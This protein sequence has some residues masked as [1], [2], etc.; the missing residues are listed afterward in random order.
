MFCYNWLV[1]PRS[2]WLHS[3]YEHVSLGMKY[4]LYDFVVLI[5]LIPLSSGIFFHITEGG[6][7]C[8]LEEVPED[9]LIAGETI[10]LN[11]T[12]KGTYKV[13]VLQGKEFL[14]SPDYGVHVEVY[15]PDMK[16]ILSRVSILLLHLI[17]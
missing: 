8:F 11:N 10:V 1:S 6:V 4:L 12:L 13:A 16:V 3:S 14:Q 17:Y 2:V 5:L 15:D 7:K 9:T